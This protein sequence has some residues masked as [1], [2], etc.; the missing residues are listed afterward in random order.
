MPLS[1]FPILSPQLTL[2]RYIYVPLGGAKHVLVNTLLVFSFVALWHDLTFRLLAWGWLISLF[3]VPELLAGYLLPA[4]KVRRASPLYQCSS[5]THSLPVSS[6]A[7][8]RGSGMCAPRA[9]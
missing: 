5:L 1:P 3:V 2:H 6:S 8:A 9:A 7:S 4:A